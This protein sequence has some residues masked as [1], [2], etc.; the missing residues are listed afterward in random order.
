MPAFVLPLVDGIKEGTARTEDA[1]AMLI[2]AACD[3]TQWRLVN[4]NRHSDPSR[5]AADSIDTTDYSVSR[6]A[7]ALFGFAHNGSR[8]GDRDVVCTTTN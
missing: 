7:F 1:I 4:T 2:K 5:R 6:L 8:F 3:G